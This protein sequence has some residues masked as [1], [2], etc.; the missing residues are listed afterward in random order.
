MAVREE[1]GLPTLAHLNLLAVAFEAVDGGHNTEDLAS[2]IQE[3]A[4]LISYTVERFGIGRARRHRLLTGFLGQCEP[5][6]ALMA[7]FQAA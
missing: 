3:I 6:F 4:D 5:V 2:F 1:S 7:E